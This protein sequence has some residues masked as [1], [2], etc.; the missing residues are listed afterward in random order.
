MLKILKFLYDSRF[1][2]FGGCIR[3]DLA[4]FHS[5]I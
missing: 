1:L 5:L 4:V 3:S 2:M